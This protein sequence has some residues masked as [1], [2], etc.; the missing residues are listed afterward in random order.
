MF[1]SNHW[2]SF[3]SLNKDRI[4]INSVYE[5]LLKILSK[6]LN[7]KF[8]LNKPI[9]YWRILIGPWLI[10]YLVNSYDKWLVV[11]KQRKEVLKKL[12]KIKI[13]NSSLLINYDINDFYEKAKEDQ[14]YYI[15][16]LRRIVNPKNFKIKKLKLNIKCNDNKSYNFSFKK[17][18]IYFFDFIISLFSLLFSKYLVD[19]NYFPKKVL[20]KIFLKSKIIPSVHRLNFIDFKRE[21]IAI[22]FKERQNV[23]IKYNQFS[24]D[25]FEKFIISNLIYDF[26]IQYFEH[27]KKNRKK[28]KLL[29]FF[30]KKIIITMVSHMFNEKFKF[31]LAEMISK[32]SKLVVIEHGGCLDY[33]F[34]SFFDHEDKISFK[35]VSWDKSENKKKIQLPVIQLLTKINH[36]DKKNPKYILFL[37]TEVLKFPMKIQCLPY[38][39]HRSK[40]IDN[41]EK[42][43]KKIDQKYHSYI[44]IRYASSMNEKNNFIINNLK[45]KFPKINF[46]NHKKGP[47]FQDDLDR[48]QVV[49]CTNAETTLAQSITRKRAT[50][51]YLNKNHYNFNPRSSKM[52][53]ILKKQNIFFDNPNALA[54]MINK[55]ASSSE[56]EWLNSYKVKSTLDLFK[57]NFFLHD[58]NWLKKW[59]NFL[60]NLC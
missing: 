11:K 58:E 49:I 5:K 31:Y 2:K 28:I 37:F 60:V 47:S 32:E 44:N 9:K 25:E 53:N 21:N 24:F 16:C 38:N 41:F 26:P 22:D 20:L 50:L 18:I 23:F 54:K 42:I 51:L 39:C 45:K 17:N 43:I 4:Y 35:R 36:Y 12:K 33:K 48:S 29:S 19:I 6:R 55:L 27:F 15:E 7:I 57:K 13:M 8:K 10:L 40:E 59:S 46:Y 1:L 14:K 34:C 3:S 52:L 56:H 30:R